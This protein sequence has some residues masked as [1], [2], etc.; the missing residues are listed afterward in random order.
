MNK[1]DTLVIIGNGFDIW[2]NLNTNYFQFKQYL[3]SH[4]DEILEA[5]QISRIK[6]TGNLWN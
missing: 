1:I 6:V 5:L 4:L 3:L 2:Q